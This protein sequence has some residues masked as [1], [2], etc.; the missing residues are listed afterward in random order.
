MAIR[1]TYDS[2][3]IDLLVGSGGLQ[4]AFKQERNQNNS[5]SGKIEHRWQSDIA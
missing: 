4:Q 1:I 2:K 3:T 5:G